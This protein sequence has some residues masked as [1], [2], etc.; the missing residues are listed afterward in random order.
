MLGHSHNTLA[1]ASGIMVAD[2]SPRGLDNMILKATS[3]PVANGN[4]RHS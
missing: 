1:A 3:R 2:T 4:L